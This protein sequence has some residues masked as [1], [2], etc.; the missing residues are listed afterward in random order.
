MG[1]VKTRRNNLI[2]P[3]VL[4]T[5]QRTRD[6]QLNVNV[7]IKRFRESDEIKALKIL[8]EIFIGGYNFYC[9][10]AVKKRMRAPNESLQD[11]NFIKGH[12]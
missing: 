7:P 3:G 1:S 10:L 11:F 2:N 12:T 6:I 4:D 8:V 9:E 5:R